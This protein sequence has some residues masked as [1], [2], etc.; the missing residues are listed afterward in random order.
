MSDEVSRWRDELQCVVD[1]NPGPLRRITVFRATDSTQ[2]AARRMNARSGEVITAARQTAGRGRMGRQWA[3]TYDDGIAVTMVLP[4]EDGGRLAIAGAVAAAHAAEATLNRRVGIKWPN[5]VIVDGRKLA[6]VLVEQVANV[7]LLGIGMN[8]LQT[9]W[10]AELA[11]RAVSMR[12]LG[13]D[14]TRL[15]ALRALLK[16]ASTALALDERQ[17][18]HEYALRDVLVGANATFNVPGERITGTVLQVDPFRGLLVGNDEGE[19]WLA[20]ATA[21]MHIG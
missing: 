13:A 15:N 11:D 14:C 3:D 1:A 21:S 4:R 12:Q 2:N 6:G 7:A 16:A 20:A 19:H 5:D 10:P 18:V 8:V 17:L 9:S